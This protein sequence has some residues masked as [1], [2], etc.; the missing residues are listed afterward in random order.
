MK[1]TIARFAIPAFALAFLSLASTPAARALDQ[2]REEAIALLTSGMW[3]FAGAD[4]S[5]DRIFNP[6]GTVLVRA[7]NA[8]GT[9]K[10]KM[11]SKQVMI[12]FGDHYDV[13]YLPID[14]KGTK[15]MDGH[16][17]EIV[18]TLIPGSGNVSA[19]AAPPSALDGLKSLQPGAA[20]ARSL[21]TADQLL[22]TKWKFDGASW[23]EIRTFLPD[24]TM[25]IENNPNLAHWQIT[26]TKII[27]TFKD[28][29]DILYLPL[30]PKGTK[31]EDS[32]G[33]LVI[34]TGAT[35]ADTAAAAPT[36]A[37]AGPPSGGSYFGNAGDKGMDATPA[38]TPAA[39][40][41]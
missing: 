8:N 40:A 24:G 39:P 2:T 9:I 1:N 36:T 15:G 22:A 26:G 19:P 29:K 5:N 38:P 4:W 18:A 16:G 14:P 32:H 34:A 6:K 41:Q 12:I 27:M 28:H 3:H 11:D 21:P 13:L 7:S 37:P 35:A 17:N 23:S 10:W 30:D 31:G 20:G 25:T 33:R